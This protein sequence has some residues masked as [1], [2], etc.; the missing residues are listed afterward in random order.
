M[1]PGPTWRDTAFCAE[2]ETVLAEYGAF[3]GISEARHLL[4]TRAAAR[5]LAALRGAREAGREDLR[6]RCGACACSPGSCSRYCNRRLISRSRR[7]GIEQ[8]SERDGDTSAEGGAVG[9]PRD[10]VQRPFRCRRRFLTYRR[11]RPDAGRMEPGP[12]RRSR[13]RTVGA[14]CL[15]RPG[16]ASARARIDPVATLARGDPLAAPA[17]PVPHGDSPSPCGR[18]T[19]ASVASRSGRTGVVI[20]AVDASWLAGDGPDGGG[21]GGR[22]VPAFGGLSAGAD[23]VAIGGFQVAGRRTCCS[24]RRAHVVARNGPR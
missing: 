11:L 7:N 17:P 22:G 23:Q 16:H 5:C 1:A 13:A 24:P 14:P 20:F 6:Y 15:S 10:R 21:Q 9:G 4:A 3:L 2:L 8:P 18:R 12:V 19:F